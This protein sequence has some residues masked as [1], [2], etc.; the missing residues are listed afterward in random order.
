MLCYQIQGYFSNQSNFRRVLA[1]G[2]THPEGGKD[3]PLDLL[4]VGGPQD[5]AQHHCHWEPSEGVCVCVC[6]SVCVCV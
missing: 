2:L 4:S 3:H 5:I 6:V 1:P